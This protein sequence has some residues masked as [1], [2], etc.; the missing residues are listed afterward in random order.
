M[1]RALRHVATE[2]DAATLVRMATIEGARALGLERQTGTLEVGKDADL[3]AVALD[4]PHTRPAPDPLVA[5]V[6][7]ARAADVMLTVVRGRVLYR[8]GTH[9][10]LERA[11]VQEAFEPITTRVAAINAQLA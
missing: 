5:L 1:Q 11:A 3:C 6:H 2:L 4:A 10:T 8:N 9:H 7:A